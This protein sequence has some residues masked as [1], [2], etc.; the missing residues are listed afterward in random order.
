MKAKL[1]KAFTLTILAG[2]GLLAASPAQAETRR[3]DVEAIV[4]DFVSGDRVHAVLIVADPTP[5]TITLELEGYTPADRKFHSTRVGARV[6]IIS[7]GRTTYNGYFQSVSRGISGA[8]FTRFRIA[9]KSW[10]VDNLGGWNLV[11]NT[12]TRP[13]SRS[14]PEPSPSSGPE[15]DSRPAATGA[16]PSLTDATGLISADAW[17]VDAAGAPADGSPGAADNSNAPPS[18]PVQSGSVQHP[19]APVAN[20]ARQPASAKVLATPGWATG[21]GW[22]LLLL[23]PVVAGGA[24]FAAFA[25][26]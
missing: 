12:F 23:V 2:G 10:T 17:P 15:D 4:G 21:G 22:I 3:P 14:G 7:A 25:R 20:G 26:G 11:S 13:V 24:M 6:F 18:M 8:N 19:A 16:A 9:I 1:I 5:G